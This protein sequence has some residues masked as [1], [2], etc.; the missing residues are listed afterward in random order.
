MLSGDDFVVVVVV[1]AAVAAVPAVADVSNVSNEFDDGHFSFSSSSSPGRPRPPFPLDDDVV[2]EFSILA[3]S[4]FPLSCFFLVCFVPEGSFD[5]ERAK[6][7]K[8]E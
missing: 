7:Q 5:A 4:L 3:N 6:T 2:E 8:Q 1:V